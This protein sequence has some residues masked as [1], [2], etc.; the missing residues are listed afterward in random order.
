MRK[1]LAVLMLGVASLGLTGCKS[2]PFDKVGTKFYEVHEKVFG[3]PPLEPERYVAPQRK[4]DAVGDNC[5]KP[6]YKKP[7]CATSCPDGSCDR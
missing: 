2:K 4:L 6:V 7:D 3:C 5:G 1:L